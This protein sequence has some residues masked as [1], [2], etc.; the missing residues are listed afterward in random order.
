MDEQT[1]PADRNEVKEIHRAF[2]QGFA[3]ELFMYGVRVKGSFDLMAREGSDVAWEVHQDNLLT[4]YGRQYL[5]YTFGLT[6]TGLFTSSNTDTPLV[7]RSLL[8][9]RYWD[10]NYTTGINATL[11]D[12]ATGS[13]SFVYNSFGAN[14]N[15]RTIGTVGL[16]NIGV[17][18]EYYSGVGGVIAYSLITPSR[19]QTGTQTLELS[20]KLTLSI[21]T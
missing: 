7:N 3:R 16:H 18:P 15:L 10:I 9:S 13:K 11:W 12:S 17:A 1:R 21:V 20:Y 8:A 6:T 5:S 4:D 14:G 2:G 19:T